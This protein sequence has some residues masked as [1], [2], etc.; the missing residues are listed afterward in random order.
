VDST[1][2]GEELRSIVDHAE[3]LLGALAD[4]GDARLGAL[5]ERV[6]ASIGTARERL[7]EIDHDAERPSERAAAAFEHWI[8]ENPWTAVAISA[9]VG[10]AIGYLL[11]GRPARSPRSA[12]SN[13]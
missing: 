6:S 3:A 11:S 13:P 5:R 4:D 9:G 7:A 2:L 8:S 10:L 1:D 12:T